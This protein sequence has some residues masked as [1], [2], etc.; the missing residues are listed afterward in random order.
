MIDSRPI[1]LVVDDTPDNITLV[2][3]LLKDEYKVKIATNGEKALKIART[4]PPDLILL[5]VMM[6][7]MDGYETCRQ[8]KMDDKL[9]DIPVIFLTAKAE[10]KDE[11]KGFELG[12][13]DYIVKPISPLILIARVKTHLNLKQAK[14][15]FVDKNQYL[16]KEVSR[17]I[18]EISLMQEVSIMSMAA[19]AEIRD[20]ET[21]YH[22]QRT[23]LY[24]NLLAN[25][26]K[27]NVKYSKLL[28][29]EN[30]DLITISAPL[31]DIGK[32]GIHDNI[33]LKPGKL[34]KEEFEIM[35][36]HASLGKEAI[37]RAETLIDKSET[38]LKFAK[39]IAG[40][41]HER[42]DGNGY[43]NGLK[44]EEIPI[45]AR[46]M[47]VA[48]VYDALISKRVYKEAFSND[49]AVK[50]IADEAGKQFNPEI[51][52]IF[53]ENKEKFREISERYKEF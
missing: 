16:E 47:A 23:K 11:S 2:S 20:N 39:E 19:L 12:A 51:V 35:K 21:G 7:V 29:Q 42:W 30:I 52:N 46:I 34:T 43:P 24:V 31:H 15:F 45:S 4:S 38:F 33:L 10:V 40:S 13:V 49:E 44:G 27:E 22:I 14:D 9:K 3:S 37:E 8:L 18:K 36:T 32:I 6:P 50:I 41:H 5:D 26:L 53:I 17:R 48:D 25:L 1:I 28:N